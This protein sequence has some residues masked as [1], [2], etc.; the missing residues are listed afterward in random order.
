MKAPDVGGG[1]SG[2]VDHRIV[3]FTRLRAPVGASGPDAVA[4]WALLVQV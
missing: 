4:R 1:A 2:I 3:R